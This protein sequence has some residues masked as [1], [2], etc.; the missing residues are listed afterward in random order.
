MTGG[1]KPD[2]ASAGR[3][4]SFGNAVSM[5]SS[6]YEAARALLPRGR[7]QLPSPPSV[8]AMGG[9][10]GKGCTRGYPESPRKAREPSRAIAAIFQDWNLAL[11][12]YVL[13]YLLNAYLKQYVYD[14]VHIL[15]QYIAEFVWALRATAGAA[16]NATTTGNV[17]ATMGSGDS[18]EFV[19]TS[20][21]VTNP[22]GEK[23]SG[24]RGIS[25]GRVNGIANNVITIWITIGFWATDDTTMSTAIMIRS[26][27]AERRGE[28]RV[29]PTADRLITIVNF[30]RADAMTM[31]DVTM[32]CIARKTRVCARVRS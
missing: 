14:G 26:A 11:F 30:S 28:A 5:G 22:I 12:V 10:L 4:S 17:E 18:V 19:T 25:V 15:N 20:P 23:A 27:K 16:S 7:P 6:S 31:K 3:S 13:V 21:A 24:E 9:C 1:A 32:N 29:S 2:T 8:M